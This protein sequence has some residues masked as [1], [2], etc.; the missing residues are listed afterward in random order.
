MG[1]HFLL[2]GI[3]SIRGLNPGLPHCRQTLYHLSYQGSPTPWSSTLQIQSH[4]YSPGSCWYMLLNSC[5]SIG[6]CLFLSSSCSKLGLGWH[7]TLFSGLVARTGLSASPEEDPC[8]LVVGKHPYYFFPR[9]E[10]RF[11]TGTDEPSLKARDSGNSVEPHTLGVSVQMSQSQ[12]QEF[13]VL[14]AGCWY[15][16]V[17][18]PWLSI[19]LSL[20]PINIRTWVCFSV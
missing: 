19:P 15:S 8:L 18:Q 11:L 9:T 2:Q 20:K 17:D 3:F 12:V 5:S 4:G 13:K 14:W 1:C 6:I 7:L 16:V 10:L